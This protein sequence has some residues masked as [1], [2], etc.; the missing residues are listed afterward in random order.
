MSTCL[1]SARSAARR[2]TRAGPRTRTRRLLRRLGR[3]RD[4]RADLGHAAQPLRV[5]Q[6]HCR[7]QRTAVLADRRRRTRRGGLLKGHRRP[8]GIQLGRGLLDR[9]CQPQSLDWVVP[10]I[11]VTRLQAMFEAAGRLVLTAKY[12]RLLHDPSVG[13]AV[14]RCAGAS[15][16]CPIRNT[17]GCCGAAPISC[18]SGSRAAALRRGRSG[19]CLLGE[20]GATWSRHEQPLL[21]IG[22]LYDCSWSGRWNRGR[23]H[24]CGRPVDPGRHAVRGEPGPG[25]R[26]APVGDDSVGA[27]GAARMHLLRARLR[28]RGIVAAVAAALPSPQRP[29]PV[30]RQGP[31][32]YCCYHIYSLTS[33]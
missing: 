11:G 28:H 6:G 30:S 24:L 23:R 15:T 27:A 20:L 12:G 25:G 29:P 33:A 32:K 31:A 7:G 26:R 21:P 19:R 17:S 14:T 18:A 16:P 10:G 1:R 2:A 22:V 3:D 5:L 13:R 4:H 9:W 8:D